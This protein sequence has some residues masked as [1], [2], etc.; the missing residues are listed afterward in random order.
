MRIDDASQALV[1]L[2]A[3]RQN[4]FHTTEAASIMSTRRL[5]RA[6]NQGVLTALGPRLWSVTA[7]GSPPGQ[8]LRAATLSSVGAAACHRG[9]GWLNGW[10]DKPPAV[11]DIWVPGHGR[12]A[13]VGVRIHRAAAIDPKL[14]VTEIDGIRTLNAAATLCLMGRVE[15]DRVIEDCLDRFL[16]EHSES[17]LLS[18]LDRL[19]TP[20]G[21][22]MPHYAGY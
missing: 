3:S 2:A 9:S 17:W 14:D 5:H 16:M 21:A 19:S 15:P 7:L 1:E 8:R 18:T 20:T 10:F 6:A 12:R 22:G 13:R 11:A 4:V